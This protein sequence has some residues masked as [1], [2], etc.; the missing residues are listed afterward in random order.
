MTPAEAFR[1][2]MNQS[3]A[4][5]A[6]TFPLTSAQQSY[7]VGRAAD[8]PLGDVGCHLYLECDGPQVD[9]PRLEEAVRLLQ[10]QHPMLRTAFPDNAEDATTLSCPTSAL[11]VT[12]LSGKSEE[13][14]VRTLSEL[15]GEMSTQ[16]LAVQDGQCLDVRL[17]VLSDTRSRLH[18]DVDLLAADPPSI[19]LLLADLGDFY[20]DG[21]ARLSVQTQDFAAYRRSHLCDAS[22]NETAWEKRLRG[23]ELSPPQFSMAVDPL[24]VTGARFVRREVT[25]SASRWGLLKAK[26]ALASIDPAS[27]LLAAYTYTLGR[28]SEGP[29][30][31]VSLPGFDRPSDLNLG[32]MV[33][34]F[35]QLHLLSVSAQS[36]PT[37]NHL[38]CALDGEV[39]TARSAAFA[40]GPAALR[41]LARSRHELL[42]PAGAVYTDL[43]DGHWTT[44]RFE[45]YF[46]PISW[47]ITQTPQVWL[48]CLV[49]PHADG[50]RLAWDAAEELFPMGMLDAMTETCEDILDA[51]VDKPWDLP[52]PATQPSGQRATR[53]CVNATTRAESGQLLHER[54]FEL[55]A[56][57]PDLPALITERATTTRGD[58]ADGA[59]RTAGLLRSL[60]VRDEDP[61]AVSLD[62]GTDQVR[63]V[64]GVLAAGACYVPIGTDQPA[65]RRA[66]ICRTAG[67]KYTITDLPSDPAADDYPGQQITPAQCLDSTALPEPLLVAPASLAYIIFTSGSTGRPKGVEISHRSAVNT[68]EDINER[69]GVGPQDR[70]LH[71]S[72]LDFDLSVYELFGLLMAGGAAVV[73]APGAARD[74]ATWL[75]LIRDH[76]ITVW[77]S[78][79]VLLDMLLT[80]SEGSTPPD[81]LR[82]VITGGDWIGTDL[83]E[84]LHAMV[85]KCVFVGCGGATEGSIYSNYYQ[86]DQVDPRWTSIPYGYPLGNQRYRVVDPSGRDRPDWVSGELWIG[87]VGVARGYRN[88]PERTAKQFVTCGNERWYRTGDMGRY[89]SDGMLEFQGRTDQ[90]VKINGYRIELGEIEAALESHEHVARAVAVVT[91]TG[92]SR[93]I[94]AYLLAGASPLDQAGV[95]EHAAARLPAYARPAHHLLLPEFPLN[96]NGKID[97]KTL[98]GWGTPEAEKAPAEPPRG[99][100]EQALAEAWT[101]I[102]ETEVTSR[103]DR[104]FDLGGD[105]IRA[106]QLSTMLYE[107]FGRRIS[108]RALLK[109]GTVAAMAELLERPDTDRQWETPRT[110]P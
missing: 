17:S 46:G 16:K 94:V 52:P 65:Q 5:D 15:R 86:A 88:D 97:R 67:V 8:E 105:S 98:A 99:A 56:A 69:W 103:H 83:P 29:D 93:R 110:A 39:R 40:D 106:M 45:Q 2:G 42:P 55:A 59:L 102:L 41:A 71:V 107:R 70:S 61:V 13:E 104:F 101:T 95:V 12:D 84:R 22:P 48:D 85:P 62:P 33:G 77:D 7:R 74:P 14:R 79:P 35:T 9:A 38:A 21:A 78:V 32:K 24:D 47:M 30:F 50:V 1:T 53:E 75:Q 58:L 31:L 3:S 66:A 73:P 28:W 60:G 44:S 37:L 6:R 89:W 81:S 76:R 90:Q 109:A 26:A 49:Y 18:V 54:F 36:A 19:R 20:A 91:G 100:S 72:A 51:F 25:M 57:E 34:D 108:L 10:K 27:V 63:A 64:L 82:L 68:L 80:A 4:E 23:R 43:L 96:G 11:S 87:G 92:L